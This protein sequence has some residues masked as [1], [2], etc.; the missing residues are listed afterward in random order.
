MGTLWRR[1]S[2]S[3]FKGKPHW[4]KNHK[5]A[6]QNVQ[7]LTPNMGQFLEARENFDPMGLFSIEW[8]DIILGIDSSSITHLHQ[9]QNLPKISWANIVVQRA[10]VCVQMTH[11]ATPQRTTIVGKATF[12]I[13]LECAD[14]KALNFELN[15]QSFNSILC[16]LYVLL[17]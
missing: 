3:K 1:L 6:F 2:R 17:N 9:G 16:N 13:K 8:L 4:G 14:T 15:P 7:M 12:F 11:I 10:F 5:I